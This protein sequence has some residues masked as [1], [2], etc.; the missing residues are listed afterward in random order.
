MN[1]REWANESLRK[2]LQN[3]EDAATKPLHVEIERLK[4]E[5]AEA[6][7]RW[8]GC[9]AA[10]YDLCKER[11]RLIDEVAEARKQPESAF[12]IGRQQ[13]LHQKEQE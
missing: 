10:Y 8:A 13:W 4:R 1:N 5:L 7:V 11:D 2:A 3:I 9:E 12:H 6:R